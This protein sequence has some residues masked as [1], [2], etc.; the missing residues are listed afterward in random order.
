MADQN[1]AQ[2]DHKYPVIT[3]VEKYDPERDQNAK[4]DQYYA[5]LQG[6]EKQIELQRQEGKT[7]RVD[8]QHSD[9]IEKTLEILANQANGPTERELSAFCNNLQTPEKITFI[10]KRAA[11]I[12]AVAIAVEDTSQ[13]GYLSPTQKARLIGY[14]T[15]T[16]LREGQKLR[17]LQKELKTRGVD[18]VIEKDT[19]KGVAEQLLR[20]NQKSHVKGIE[21]QTATIID[22]A[23]SGLNYILL[24][25]ARERLRVDP[26]TFRLESKKILGVEYD[27]NNADLVRNRPDGQN[28]DT[29][30]EDMQKI[31]MAGTFLQVKATTL[32][33]SGTIN[34]FNL[35]FTDLQLNEFAKGIP[36]QKYGFGG[37]LAAAT[38]ELHG[39]SNLAG[40]RS[41]YLPEYQR[42]EKYL[43]D[44]IEIVKFL[45]DVN[46]A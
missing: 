26:S 25:D 1:P 32:N 28:P 17:D 33:R 27:L 13:P 40:V 46:L 19:P 42:L 38:S 6:L 29:F 35:P 41:K 30:I 5:A 21:G 12:Y 14:Y 11:Q 10:S 20:I 22:K 7:E 45:L 36:S 43:L 15:R 44:N 39:P 23:T 37:F 2:Q 16:A 31:A 8:Q 34:H 4:L 24:K 18:L 3:Q 9:R